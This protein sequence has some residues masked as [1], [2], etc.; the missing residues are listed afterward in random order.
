M[1]IIGFVGFL[2]FALHA[3][4]STGP[5][6]FYVPPEGLANATENRGPSTGEVHKTVAFLGGSITE[7]DGFRPRVMRQLRA[8]Y[9]RIAF[10]EIAAGLS[11][12]CSDAGAFRLDEDVLS[13]GVPDLFVVEAAV[14][15]DQDGHFSFDHCVR[16]MEGC[17]RRVLMKNP[18]CAVVVGL[19]VNFEQYQQLTNGVTPLQYAAHAQVARHYGAALADVGSALARSGKMTWE[20]YKD[21]HPSPEGCDLGADVVMSAIETVFDPC[22]RPSVR[23]LPS[24]IDELSYYNGRCVSFDRVK[25]GAGWQVSRPSWEK[26]EGQKRSYFT[27]EDALWTELAG[28]EC[29]FSFS[30]TA[31]AAFLTAGPDAGNLE[32][33][34]DGAPFKVLNLR[35]EFGE[36]HYPYVQFIADG[37]K[38]GSHAVRL[39]STVA[40]RDAGVGTA[41]RIHRLYMNG[42]GNELGN[43]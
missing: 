13:K 40:H 3:V 32:V 29:E 30:G 41:I 42:D 21:C 1:R 35:A 34:V 8:K 17:V 22:A 36:L 16:G 9:P 28:A 25:L 4:G 6:T 26:I 23:T 14:N 15:D 20:E 19:M 43:F 27:C 7:M 2:G 37:L 38:P 31:V 12:T 10:T 5:G 18:S 11:S 39:R 24:P 33:S